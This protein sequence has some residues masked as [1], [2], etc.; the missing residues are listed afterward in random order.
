[1]FFQYVD[2]G[3]VFV[4]IVQIEI[5]G[6]TMAEEEELQTDEGEKEVRP[7]GVIKVFFWS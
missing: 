4:Y 6:F 5:G 3:M 1:M 7:K 2:S